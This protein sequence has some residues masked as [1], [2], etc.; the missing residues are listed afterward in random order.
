MFVKYEV[1]YEKI[2]LF[3]KKTV[4][5]ANSGRITLNGK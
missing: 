4:F 5:D 2:E 1:F 3:L